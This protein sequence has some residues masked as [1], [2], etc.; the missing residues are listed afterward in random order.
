[1]RWYL[2][3]E[4]AICHCCTCLTRD[5]FLNSQLWRPALQFKFETLMF[6]IWLVS[7][8]SAINLSESTT[9]VYSSRDKNLMLLNFLGKE[10][11]SA[12]G[13]VK[14]RQGCCKVFVILQRWEIIDLPF[15][16]QWKWCALVSIPLILQSQA[17]TCVAGGS[18]VLHTW[19][20]AGIT[21]CAVSHPLHTE[22]DDSCETSLCKT[23][24]RKRQA[25]HLRLSP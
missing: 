6:S 22:K 2:L 19:G 18:L 15:I 23:N 8:L 12:A 1:M 24:Q 21:T 17:A 4:Y 13:G 7:K 20:T 16:R 10:P 5:L 14:L 25:D 9:R 3:Q 11:F